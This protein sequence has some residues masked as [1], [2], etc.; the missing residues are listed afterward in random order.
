MQ[1]SDAC[2]L[3]LETIQLTICFWVGTRTFCLRTSKAL[4]TVLRVANP[5]ENVWP[6]NNLTKT[7][8]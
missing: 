7:Y 3:I 2:F 4:K 1:K 5:Y 6:D 8:Y